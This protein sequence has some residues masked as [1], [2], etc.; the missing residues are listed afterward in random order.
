MH[1]HGE[2]TPLEHGER[3]RVRRV[4]AAITLPLLVATLAGLVAL[5]PGENPMGSLPLQGEDSEVARARVTEIVP[6]GGAEL[7][8][9]K[10]ADVRGLLLS[11]MGEGTEVP[12]QVPG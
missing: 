5:W 12:I 9:G 10:G 3:R 1:S 6:I 8:P 2:V 4:L 7:D 11:G